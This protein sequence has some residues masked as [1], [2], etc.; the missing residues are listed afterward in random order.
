MNWQNAV[1]ATVTGLG[2][3]IVDCERTPGGLLR[4][5]IDVMAKPVEEGAQAG[6]ITVEDC[7]RVTRQLQYVLEVEACAY[8][9]LEVSS[10]GLDR[11]LKKAADYQRFAGSEIDL[12]LKLAFQ[13]RKKYR[14]L[15]SAEGDAWR[16]VFNDGKVDQ[17][18]DFSL[19]EVREA[20]LVPVI[21]FKGR[22]QKPAI[23]PAAVN[24][25]GEVSDAM[26]ADKRV[27]GGP[28]Q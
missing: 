21:D 14:G 23:S 27:D 13:G 1:E 24:T 7:E 11:P 17:A 15:L 22:R 8:E 3:D 5:Y 16:I 4:V 2:Y 10:P 19:D 9:R 28:V 6:C 12:T 20:R 26:V 18:L 25:A